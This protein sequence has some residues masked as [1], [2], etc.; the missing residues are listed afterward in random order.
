MGSQLELGQGT[1]VSAEG[2]TGGIYRSYPADFLTS[3]V[4]CSVLIDQAAKLAARM[5][6]EKTRRADGSGSLTE[7]DSGNSRLEVGRVA[8]SW[9]KRLRRVEKVGIE[10]RQVFI[11][12]WSTTGCYKAKMRQGNPH[13]IAHKG[14]C[15]IHKMH[16]TKRQ[17]SSCGQQGEQS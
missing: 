4:A 7:W 10:S 11:D 8:R 14:A 9:I 15:E 1:S 6:T 17:T 13:T 5:R 2:A 12:C 16:R 3:R